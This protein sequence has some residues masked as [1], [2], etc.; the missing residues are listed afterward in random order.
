LLPQLQFKPSIAVK[1]TAIVHVC[2][3]TDV[4]L[5]YY[6][7]EA[8][9]SYCW[10]GLSKSGS[11]YYWLD[12]NPSI[13]RNWVDGEPNEHTECVRIVQNGRFRDF[14]CNR[15][16]YRYVCKGIWCFL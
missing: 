1:L 13:Y 16:Y 9:D 6:S 12:G 15:N 2:D 14:Y 3:I 4:T 7:N 8:G 11:D 5:L 10:I